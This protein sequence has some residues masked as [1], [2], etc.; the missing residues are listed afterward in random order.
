MKLIAQGAEAKLYKKSNVIIKDRFPKKYRIKE[1]DNKLRKSRTK[2]EAKVLRK[3]E[4]L[5]FPCPKVIEDD[6]FKSIE[7][8][9]LE[10]KMLRDV[11]NSTNFKKLTTEIGKKLAFLHNHEIIHG[12]LTTSNMIKEK[13]IY[14]IDFGLSFFSHKV[15]DKAVDI[16]LV[17]EALESRHHQI[18]KQAYK[19]FLS[20][21][22]KEANDEKAIL[23][24]LE[25]V[26][27]RGR[28]KIK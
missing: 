14:F 17:K 15:E 16:H 26:E 19:S 12:D 18:A 28:Y 3:L 4:A 6:Q 23:K 5:H 11:L 25:I 20:A 21:Y 24:R 27:K 7:M 9:F 2:R 8:Q 1:I 10:G 13:E 22:K